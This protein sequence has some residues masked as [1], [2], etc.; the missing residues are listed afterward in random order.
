[1]IGNHCHS[2]GIAPLKW[3][4]ISFV[5]KVKV[6]KYLCQNSNI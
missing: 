5:K 4:Y 1:M 3:L 6:L 2:S